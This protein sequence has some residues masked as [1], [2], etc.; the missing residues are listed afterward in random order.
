MSKGDSCWNCDK[1]VGPDV[2]RC[3]SCGVISVPRERASLAT[4]LVRFAMLLIALVVLV[5][6]FRATEINPL[7]LIEN[8]H[9]AHGY[10]FGEAVTPEVE[11]E[12]RKIAERMPD[13]IHEMAAR[14]T[15]QRQA[16][17]AGR[18]LTPA[19]ETKLVEEEAE[20]LRAAQPEAERERIINEEVERSLARRQEGYF[21]PVTDAPRLRLY[22][23]ALLET[24]AIA[25]W[26]TLLAIV[27][28]VPVAIFAA[29]RGM[30][31]MTPGDTPVRRTIR[32]TTI[33]FVRRFLD[34]CRGFNE[35]VLALI[36]VVVIGLGPFAGVLALFVHTVG[37]LGKQISETIEEADRGQLEG[38]VAT[39][40]HP[41]QVVSFGLM[42]QIIP[43]TVS[44]SLLRFETN[45]RSATILGFCGAGGIGKFMVDKIN[46]YSYREVCTMM[47]IIIV[48]V[49]II[50]FL[51]G[52]LRKRF[53]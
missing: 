5:L 46:G 21:P 38:V 9:R 29:Q 37:V 44:F 17:E 42:P 27:V 47:I 16:K 2:A 22:F 53:I 48:V 30:Q 33:F 18:V 12:V 24:L 8:R 14:E 36:L 51:C 3:E 45:V 49:A 7:K 39:G 32:G 41:L 28:A 10:F 25:L 43:A 4:R 52:R 13:T 34:F 35:Y 6:S 26:G 40:A 19:E 15:V 23:A 20:R 50:D 11:A 1:P 31:I